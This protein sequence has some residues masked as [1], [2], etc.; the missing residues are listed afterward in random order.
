MT[1]LVVGMSPHL[2]VAGV[3]PCGMRAGPLKFRERAG[4]PEASI[5]AELVNDRSRALLVDVR[6]RWGTEEKVGG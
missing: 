6:T 5:T 2:G 4:V 1:F 3:H